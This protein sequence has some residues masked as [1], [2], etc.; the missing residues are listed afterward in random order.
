[1]LHTKVTQSEEGEEIHRLK[2]V[3]SV[4]MLG[5]MIDSR[6]NN[7]EHINYIKKKYKKQKK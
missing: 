2:V 6:S 7:L 1:M 5:Y 4:K 3:R